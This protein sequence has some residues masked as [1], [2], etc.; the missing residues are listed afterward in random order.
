M[1]SPRFWRLPSPSTVTV[2]PTASLTWASLRSE[3]TESL[4]SPTAPWKEAG[5]PC[6][7]SGSTLIFLAG[8]FR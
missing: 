6:S 2:R 8:A 3:L 7:G 5:L 1:G 4:K